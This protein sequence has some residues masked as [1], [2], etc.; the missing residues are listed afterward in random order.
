MLIWLLWGI[1][2]EQWFST[3]E[4]AACP[5]VPPGDIWAKGNVWKHFGLR[6]VGERW[7]LLLNIVQW[8][9]QPLQESI[10]WPKVSAVPRI[11]RPVLEFSFL[12][13]NNNSYSNL[14][15]IV[16]ATWPSLGH[17]GRFGLKDD[18]MTVYSVTWIY[19]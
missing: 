13:T 9:E 11:R 1:A 3:V 16:E 12:C 10:S 8:T 15:G 2:L 6:L 17:Q 4:E 7:G 18:I 5:I 14:D 19:S